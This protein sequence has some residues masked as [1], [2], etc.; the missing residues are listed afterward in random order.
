MAVWCRWSSLIVSNLVYCI[1]LWRVL[2][3]IGDDCRMISE[4]MS[5]AIKHRLLFWTYPTLVRM[6][7]VT[8][9]FIPRNTATCVFFDDHR[10]Y[11]VTHHEVYNPDTIRSTCCCSCVFFDFD[12]LFGVC[13]YSGFDHVHFAVSVQCL[14]YKTSKVV[15]FHAV[16]IQLLRPRGVW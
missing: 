16:S 15:C 6:G 5:R 9:A 12:R 10:P 1:Y 13:P 11:Y 3:Y 14:P 7:G 8:T 4:H 2:T